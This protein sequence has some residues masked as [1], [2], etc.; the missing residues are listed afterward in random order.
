V[1]LNPKGSKLLDIGSGYGFF[2]DEA[3]KKGLNVTGVEPS[4]ELISFKS[5]YN[6]AIINDQFPTTKLKNEKFDFV[7]LIHVI[8]H[9]VDPLEIIKHALSHLKNG[10]I[11]YIETPNLDSHLYRFENDRY[12]FL[13]PPD[14]IFL[15]S[16]FSFKHMLLNIGTIRKINTYSYPQH[17][18][19]IVKQMVKK[20]K[21]YD[22]TVTNQHPSNFQNKASFTKRL[23]YVLFDTI[24]A[25]ILY[26]LLNL[27]QQGS[28]LELY[29]SK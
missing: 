15:F 11:L 2:L 14:H 23:K 16:R 24:L 19:G 4:K 25:R 6:V 21:Q 20:T 17:L 26:P 3:E 7:T 9:L 13:T 1:Q 12:T 28:I 5:N 10:G 22:M 18:M 8:E 27:N 29:I